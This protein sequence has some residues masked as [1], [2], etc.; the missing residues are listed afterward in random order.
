MTRRSRT[1]QL[2]KQDKIQSG[3]LQVRILQN[4]ITDLEVEICVI[5]SQIIFGIEPWIIFQIRHSNNFG[6][7]EKKILKLQTSQNVFYF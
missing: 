3:L 4:R 5:F 2:A 6:L 1:N 7:F